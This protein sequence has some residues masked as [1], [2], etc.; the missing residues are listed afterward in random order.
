MCHGDVAT[1]YWQWGE[2]KRIPI[3]SL[4]IT[5]TCRDFEAIKKWAKEH[6][7]VNDELVLQWHPGPIEDFQLS[8]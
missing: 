7:I 5:H 3:P 8:G 1:V 2:E 4:A 6:V